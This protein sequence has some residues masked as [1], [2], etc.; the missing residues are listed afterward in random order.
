MVAN[1]SSERNRMVV[2]GAGK[3]QKTDAK[4]E[5]WKLEV[6]AHSELTDAKS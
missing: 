5:V 4:F 3:G 2:A 1:E 6:R